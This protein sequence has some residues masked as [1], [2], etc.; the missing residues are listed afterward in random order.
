MINY[1]HVPK[2][3]GTSLNVYLQDR[4]GQPAFQDRRY[5]KAAAPVPWNKTSPQHIDV[6]AM[7]RLFPQGFFDLT[8]AM[9]RDPQH[10][11]ASV[12]RFQRGVQRKI[13]RVMSFSV[14]LRW[15]KLVGVSRKY[16][17]DNHAMPQSQIVPETATA[18]KLEDG[19]KPLIDFLD[20]HLGP[21]EV[22]GDIGHHNKSASETEISEADQKL[23]R[24]LYAVDYERFGYA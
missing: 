20:N 2:C 8:F 21:S 12:Y 10:R 1:V 22:I 5:F 6:E 19:F 18:F 7:E 3:A 24:E 13:P 15:L 17:Y 16:R 23:I 14:W 9:V 11:L 4:L